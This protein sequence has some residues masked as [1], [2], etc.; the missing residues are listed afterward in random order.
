VRRKRD[1]PRNFIA[2]S[3]DVTAEAAHDDIMYPSALP[4]V[5]VHL[6]C[7]AAI[8]SGVTGEALALCVMLYLLRM[9]AIGAGYH[10]YFSHRSYSTSRVFQFLLAFSRPE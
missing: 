7:I 1:T 8:W 9:F 10:R 6:G 4:F 2:M 5:L 3:P